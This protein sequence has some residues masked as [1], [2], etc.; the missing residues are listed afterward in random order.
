MLLDPQMNDTTAE[1]FLPHVTESLGKK[2]T[3]LGW[4]W[5]FGVFKKKF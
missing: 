2:C 4:P 5:Y 3:E 1:E